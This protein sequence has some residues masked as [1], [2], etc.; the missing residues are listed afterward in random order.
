MELSRYS[1]AITITGMLTVLV[2]S[3]LVWLLL[4]EPVALADPTAANAVIEHIRKVGTLLNALDARC[5]VLADEQSS[6]RERVAG[7]LDG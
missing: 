6:D 2:A 7:R 3:M 1:L 5:I 4:T